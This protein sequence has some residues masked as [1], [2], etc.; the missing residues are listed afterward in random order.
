MAP[1]GSAHVAAGRLSPPTPRSGVRRAGRNRE[2][3]SLGSSIGGAG[4]W[5][6]QGGVGPW[7]CTAEMHGIL[8]VADVSDQGRGT[9]DPGSLL[10]SSK[11][12]QRH[13]RSPKLDTASTTARF[14]EFPTTRFDDIVSLGSAAVGAALSNVQLFEISAS[15]SYE[16][17]SLRK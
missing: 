7:P 2:E 4:G 11:A 15:S 1:L 3:G 14:S 8:H 16:K 17:E 12:P 6:F 10:G 9:G 13:F 5:G